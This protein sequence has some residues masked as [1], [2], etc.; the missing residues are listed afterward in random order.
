MSDSLFPQTSDNSLLGL[1]DG[2]DLGGMALDVSLNGRLFTLIYRARESSFDGTN[3]NTAHGIVNFAKQY[4]CSYA[5]LL[6]NNCWIS[7]TK[8][9]SIAAQF[10][11]S[12]KLKDY[13]L[14]VVPFDEAIYV[15]EIEDSLV[16][17]E[18]VYPVP[19][20]LEFL[21]EQR[22]RQQDGLQVA[23][24]SGGMAVKALY[25]EGFDV[26]HPYEIVTHGK[27]VQT[28]TY[29][30]INL[31]LLKH[32]LYHPLL[33]IPA[34]AIVGLILSLSL[35][36]YFYTKEDTRVI[37]EQTVEQG[38]EQIQE[39]VAVKKPNITNNHAAQ[40][41]RQIRPLILSPQIDFLKTCRLTSI[42][43]GT[44]DLIYQGQWMNNLL[45]GK[46][47]CGNERLKQV[48]NDNQLQL[49]RSEDGWV[50]KGIELVA[51]VQAVPR[52]PTQ[53]TLNQ[54]ELFADYIGWQINTQSTD[55]DGDDLNI[56]L[57]LTGDQLDGYI[58][59]NLIA[60]LLTLPARMQQGHLQFNPDS[61]SVTEATFNITLFAVGEYMQ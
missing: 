3:F 31:L 22:S 11:D 23:I 51:N 10:E 4:D 20:G 49:V 41:L 30:S 7:E 15:A 59:D 47:G 27:A 28:Y 37:V 60:K 48:I 14:I 38:V 34:G 18:K 1:P 25:Q 24:L 58:L 52:V 16:S 50:I 44:S 12:P 26:N 19:K 9:L 42:I 32:K 6:G 21:I 17:Q 46:E 2:G 56:N 40:I 35:L 33:L 8:G 54:L 55:R 53:Q 13:Q 39:I 5:L 57:A 29:Q 43:I 36:L 45:L 61:L